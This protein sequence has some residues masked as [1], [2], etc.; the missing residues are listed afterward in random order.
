MCVCEIFVLLFVVVVV[1]VV[2]AYVTVWLTEKERK[3]HTNK[4][5]KA[6]KQTHWLTD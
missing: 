1:V 3:N 2:V 5:T 6:S 4:Q